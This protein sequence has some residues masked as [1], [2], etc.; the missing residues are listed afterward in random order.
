MNQKKL[1]IRFIINKARE[2][3]Q[4]K[5]PL[6]CRMTYGQTR[7]QFATGHFTS[8][9]EWD[10]QKQLSTKKLLNS[11]IEVIISNIRAAYLKLQLEKEY[12]NVEDIYNLYI[13][14]DEERKSIP[15]TLQY[16]SDYLDHIKRLIGLDITQSTFNKFQYI[17]NQAEEFVQWKYSTKDIALDRLN[18][19]FLAD[20]EHYLKTERG[21]V[22]ITVNKAIQRFRKP[23]RRAVQEGIL[24]VDPFYSYKPKRVKNGIVFLTS[25]ELS[26]LEKFKFTQSRLKYIRDLFIFSCYTGLPYQEVMSLQKMDIQTSF[27][28]KLWISIYRKK[29]SR[30]L[31][32]PLLP[33]ALNIIEKYKSEESNVFPRISN[34]KVNSYLKE[35]AD[36]VGINKRITHHTARKTFASTVLLYNDVP[37]EIVSELLGHSSIKITQEYYGKIVQKRISEEMRRISKYLP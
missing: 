28:K 18:M 3:K 22:Q 21:Q 16:F 30:N 5:C 35:I 23:V 26:K 4:G 33:K 8:Y 7:K 19:K 34:Q 25:D 17:Y 1:S 9:K 20:F 15:G 2:N 24:S 10:S 29:T 27:D 37:M 11:Q 36:I 13:G 31:S 14:K 32:V 6:Y 12:F